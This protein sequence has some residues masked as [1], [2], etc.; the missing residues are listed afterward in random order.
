MHIIVE[1]TVAFS[2]HEC[3]YIAFNVDGPQPSIILI[4]VGYMDYYFY[5]YSF[6]LRSQ[7]HSIEKI[8]TEK[9]FRTCLICYYMMCVS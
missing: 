4:H 3:I 7:I 5:D 8:G 9:I 1:A 6:T 2:L